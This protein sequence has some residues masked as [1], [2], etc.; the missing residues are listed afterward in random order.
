MISFVLC[1]NEKGVDIVGSQIVVR[2]DHSTS[3]SSSAH[4]LFLH[5]PSASSKCSKLSCKWLLLVH[6]LEGV[7][8]LKIMH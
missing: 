3:G 6:S 7:S 5:H 1:T 2:Y 8:V 4:I